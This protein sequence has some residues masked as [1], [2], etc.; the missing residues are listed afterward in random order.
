MSLYWLEGIIQKQPTLSAKT[1]AQCLRF[2]SR[3]TDQHYLKQA[4]NGATVDILWDHLATAK[5][6]SLDCLLT[7]LENLEKLL[8]WRFNL[9][10]GKLLRKLTPSFHLLISSLANDHEV[11]SRMETDSN[12]HLIQTVKLIRKIFQTIHDRST[13]PCPCPL[14][15]HKNYCRRC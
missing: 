14:Q 8:A 5:D 3:L 15:S 12:A 4:V 10:A 11:K 7:G 9:D 6:G 2:F 13:E 1:A